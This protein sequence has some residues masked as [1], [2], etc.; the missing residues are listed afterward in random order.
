LGAGS[1]SLVWPVQISNTAIAVSDHGLYDLGVSTEGETSSPSSGPEQLHGQ[2]GQLESP[3]ERRRSQEQLMAKTL[4]SATNHA[5]AIRESARREAELTLRKARAEAE[6]LK[7]GAERERDA[8]Q[9]ELLRLRRITEQMRSGLSAF[10]TSKVEE[11]R[12]ETEGATNSGQEE[13]LE[14]ALGS[15]LEARSAT[16]LHGSAGGPHAVP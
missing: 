4:I 15:A 5:I 12:L 2:I 10:L 9:R 14:T 7:A 8:A 11:L 6:K 3:L 16:G 1:V 13:E